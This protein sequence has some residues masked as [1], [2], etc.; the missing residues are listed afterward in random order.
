MANVKFKCVM[1][2]CISTDKSSEHILAFDHE[3]QRDTPHRILIYFG[4]L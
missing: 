4:F 3:K 2:V 1:V